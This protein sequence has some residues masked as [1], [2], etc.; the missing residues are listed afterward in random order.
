MASSGATV[1]RQK[2]LS[3]LGSTTPRCVSLTKMA[4]ALLL[5]LEPQR[6]RSQG[7]IQSSLSPHDA[8]CRSRTQK[9]KLREEEFAGRGSFQGE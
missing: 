3:Q 8:I 4:N 6:A 2:A 9:G 1:G 5:P 7:R